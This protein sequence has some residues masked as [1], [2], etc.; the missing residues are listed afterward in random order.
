MIKRI[1]VAQVE[2]AIRARL[3][4]RPLFIN[5]RTDVY[6]RGLAE[7]Q[8]AI[9]MSVERLQ[10]YAAAGR[11]AEAKRALSRAA[12]AHFPDRQLAVKALASL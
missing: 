1:I 8:A 11:K 6:L 9:A 2:T 3:E 7:G 5:A 12:S 4:G 10:A